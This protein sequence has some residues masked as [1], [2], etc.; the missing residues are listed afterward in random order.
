MLTFCS[1][2][3]SYKQTIGD[4]F[5]YTLQQS[6]K[7]DKAG[8]HLI[9]MSCGIELYIFKVFHEYIGGT[10]SALCSVVRGCDDSRNSL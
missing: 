8:M 5:V 6:W 2:L 9:N 4:I 3:S 7:T 1:F 10:Q